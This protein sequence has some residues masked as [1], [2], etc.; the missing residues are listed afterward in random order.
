MEFSNP[1]EDINWASVV[2]KFFSFTTL[3]SW[4]AYSAKQASKHYGAESH[5][6]KMELELASIDPYLAILP[7]EER[8]NVKKELAGK[9]FGRDSLQYNVKNKDNDNDQ[10]FGSSAIIQLVQEILTSCGRSLPSSI[11]GR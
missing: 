8:N 5:N 3:G 10:N 7:E 4:T 9:L 2:T 6:R 11:S 1:G